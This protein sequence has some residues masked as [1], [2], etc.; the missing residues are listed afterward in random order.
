MKK[1]SNK[2]K[3]NSKKIVKRVIK[4]KK[5]KNRS[6]PNGILFILGASLSIFLTFYYG[7][8]VGLQ[9]K[10]SDFFSNLLPVFMLEAGEYTEILN[11]NFIVR[12]KL[13]DENISIKNTIS[14]PHTWYYD[15]I[16]VDSNDLDII[17][18]KKYVISSPDEKVKLTIIP[19]E[20]NQFRSVMSAITQ[21]EVTVLSDLKANKRCLGSLDIL[22]SD[23]FDA[24]SI[25]REDL[26]KNEIKYV[27]E[28]A[29]TVKPA[30]EPFILGDFTV[31]KRDGGF[32]K[33]DET[34]WTGDINLRIDKSI[35]EAE[36]SAYLSIVD[37]IVSSLR[38][39]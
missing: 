23:E 37:H 25:Y 36:K 11:K 29:S 5:K 28:V 4:D 2:K 16:K 35:S 38:I 33:G 10:H 27:Q 3:V 21:T 20:I 12:A 9:H 32:I 13:N 15:E 24:V 31:F 1:K 30:D 14:F 6:I 17:G 26:G 22:G 18:S 39:E 8:I 7:Y 19:R 34:V